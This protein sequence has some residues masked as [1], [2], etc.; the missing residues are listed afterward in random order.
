MRDVSIREWL[1]RLRTWAKTEKEKIAGIPSARK[2]VIYIWEYYKLWII[3]IVFV[4]WFGTFAY[5]QYTTVLHDYW[6]YMIFANTY[7]DLGDHSKLW[8]DYTEYAGFDLN[9]KAVVFNASSYFDYLKGVTGNSYFEAFVAFA[10]S[11]TLDGITMGT[12]SLAALGETGRLMDLESEACAS[13][14]AKYS[15]RFVYC[16]AVREDGETV[17]A[18]VGIDISDSRLVTEYEGYAEPCALGIAALSDNVESVELFLDF[19][20]TEDDSRLVRSE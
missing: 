5:H 15:D 12:E 11:G 4:L 13:I 16:D 14:A 1:E 6:C 20:L 18:A 9:E 8:E 10:D 2:K 17:H 3:G 19:I 7:A